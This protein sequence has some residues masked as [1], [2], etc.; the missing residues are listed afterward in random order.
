MREKLA[1]DSIFFSV[2]ER[3]QSLSSLGNSLC[4]INEKLSNSRR[5]PTKQCDVQ[6]EFL[7]SVFFQGDFVTLVGLKPPFGGFVYLDDVGEGSQRRS[8]YIRCTIPA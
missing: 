5:V 2:N 8:R 6:I 7:C 3:N 4:Y 1:I